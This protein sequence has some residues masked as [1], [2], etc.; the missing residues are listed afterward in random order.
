[1]IWCKKAY[2]ESFELITIYQKLYLRLNPANPNRAEPNNHAA[3]GRGI[4]YVSRT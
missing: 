1:M 4:A 2:K 3:A